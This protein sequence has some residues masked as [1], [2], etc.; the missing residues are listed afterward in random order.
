MG[1]HVI[2]SFLIMGV[3]HPV[4]RHQGHEES[5]QISQHP[6]IS[7]LIHD[8]GAAGVE[9]ADHGHTHIE[10]TGTNP[11]IQL[12]RDVCEPLTLGSQAKGMEALMQHRNVVAAELKH[13]Q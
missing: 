1:R 3:G 7:V 12:C 9:A 8:Q 11:G 4:L 6:R 10:T 13:L 2:R 5:S